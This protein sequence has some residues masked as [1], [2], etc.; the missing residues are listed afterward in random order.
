MSDHLMKYTNEKDTLLIL[1]I[2]L[3]SSAGYEPWMEFTSFK[4]EGIHRQFRVV[5]PPSE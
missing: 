1:N 3:K 4:F 2:W 5:P